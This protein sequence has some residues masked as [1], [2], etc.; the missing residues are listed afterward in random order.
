M[1]QKGVL[2]VLEGSDGSGKTTQ[3]NLLSER[4]KAIGY[5][6]SVFDF[7]RYDK[8]SSYFI[9]QYLNGRYGPAAKISPYTA[10]LFYALDRYEAAK[11][12]R[13]ELDKGRVVLCNRYVGSNM[14]HQGSKFDD[15]VEQ[16]GFFVWEDNLEFQL[17]NIP[18]PDI[19]L[20]LRVPAE[21]SYELIRNKSAR[22]YTSKTHDEHEGDIEHLKR[23]VATY[24]LLCQ[25]FPKDFSAIECSKNN[26]MLDIPEIS[27][28][29][30]N[31]LKPV[32]PK[33]IPNPGHSAVVTVGEKLNQAQAPTNSDTEKLTQ[34]FKTSSLLLKL[35]IEKELKSVEPSGFSVW[36]DSGY[37]FYTPQGLPKQLE[38]TYKS[39]IEHIG[40]LHQQMRQMLE[41][42]YEKSLLAQANGSPTLP[43]ISSLLLPVTPLSALSN[44]TATLSPRSIRRVCG[45]L[46]ANDSSELQWAAKQLYLAARQAW[47]EDFSQPLESDATPEPLNNI[48]A[49][50]AEDKLS[51][52]S[53]D[54]RDVRLL[55]A[56]PRQ[57]FDLLAETIYPYSSLSLEEITEEVSDWSYQQKFDSLK[58][59][60]SDPAVLLEKIQYKFDLITDQVV[61]QEIVNHS[62]VSNLQAQTPSPRNGYEVPTA[63]E[64]AGI[65]DLYMECFDES[66]KLFSLLQQAERD[67]LTV[68]SALLGH[69]LRW[70]LS[71]NARDMRSILDY[72]GDESYSKVINTIRDKVSEVHPLTWEVLTGTSSSANV[73]GARKNR[74]KPARR[75]QSKRKH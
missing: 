45:L 39:T 32:L 36:S 50:L 66:L 52:N 15:P 31:R 12:I 57:E 41:V 71:V 40:H 37:K 73:T 74:V 33:D 20:F 70:Q 17:L 56:T 27:N 1:E 2:I 13:R 69:K 6:V 3:F 14:A 43:N 38:A 35:Q 60:A 11:E 4:L 63:I 22:S 46:L 19:N 7:P 28:L 8:E 25:L 59:A 26:Q 18:R 30:W 67:D 58:Q 49:K 48:I 29:I 24:D 16:R 23:S 61:M 10:S 47:P 55:E 54:N 68:Y 51:L 62:V 44:F 9:K 42:Y 72:N 53:S 21:V 34:E 65:E 5:D 75:R 64:E